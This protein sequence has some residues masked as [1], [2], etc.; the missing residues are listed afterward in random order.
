MEDVVHLM[1]SMFLDVTPNPLN[2]LMI[3]LNASF[4][5]DMLVSVSDFS[6]TSGKTLTTT[7]GGGG[8]CG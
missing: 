7:G 8:G 4:T 5:A 6:F 2:P 1:K 3:E